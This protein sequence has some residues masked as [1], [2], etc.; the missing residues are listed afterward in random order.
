MPKIS[1]GIR[2]R[3]YNHFSPTGDFQKT[4]N[5]GKK[6]NEKISKKK[7]MKVSN[8]SHSPRMTIRSPVCSQNLSKKSHEKTPFLKKSDI[9]C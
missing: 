2:I 4:K 6:F 7:L 1:Q 3:L 9:V 8:E 5:P